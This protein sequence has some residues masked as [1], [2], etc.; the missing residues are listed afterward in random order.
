MKIAHSNKD[1]L[2]IAETRQAAQQYE[3]DG[4]LDDAVAAYLSL[5]KKSPREEKNYNRLMILYRK[6]KQPKKEMEMITKA[7]NVFSKQYDAKRKSSPRKVSQ[8]SAALMKATGLT[9]KKNLL[10]A[11]EGHILAS[12][13]LM[14]LYKKKKAVLH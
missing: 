9:D 5:L 10:R 12:G 4:K 6:L 8:L 14:G 7:I 11:M 3:Q 2:S 13:S 1:G